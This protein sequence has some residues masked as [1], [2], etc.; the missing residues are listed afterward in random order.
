MATCLTDGCEYNINIDYHKVS[1]E[2]YSPV[3]LEDETE[4]KDRIHRGM[5]WALAPYYVGKFQDN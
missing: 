2:V 4:L 5:E 1:C 3:K